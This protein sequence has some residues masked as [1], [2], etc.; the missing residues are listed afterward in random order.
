M[1]REVVWSFGGGVQSVALLVL[2][3]ESKLAKPE[4]VIMSD[5]GRESSLT[6]QYTRGHA[7]PL[8]E[9]LG[10][11]LEIASHELATVDL[12]SHKGTLLIPAFTQT[13]KFSTYCSSEWKK[14]VNRRYLRSQGYGPEKP[15][16]MWFGMSLDEIERMRVSDVDWIENWYPLCFDEKLRRHECILTIERFGLPIPPK[17][18]CWMC[19]NRSDTEWLQQKQEA[20]D[21]HRKAVELDKTIRELDQM[22]ELYLHDSRMPLD[23]VEF[24]VVDKPKTPMEDCANFC[25]T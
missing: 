4:R 12:Y 25:W 22:K 11:T 15:I 1:N 20:P 16:R 5:T 9:S 13:G 17:S 7:I 14:L 8:L 19:P 23:E 10:L 18:A 24:S 2:I 6:W 3:A 21:D